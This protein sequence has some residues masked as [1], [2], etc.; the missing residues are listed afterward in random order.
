MLARTGQDDA[1][2]VDDRGDPGAGEALLAHQALQRGRVDAHH[3]EVAQAAADP[4]RHLDREI[5]VAADLGRVQVGHQDPVLAVAPHEFRQ[6]GDAPQRQLGAE[7]TAGVEQLAAVGGEQDHGAG[8]GR[9]GAARVLVEFAQVAARQRG[10]RR[11]GAQH[12]GVGPDLVVH[13]QGEGAR[14]LAHAA[15]LGFLL[16][17]VDI[18][19]RQ[20][21]RREG[22]DQD[23]E[24][25]QQKAVADT[26]TNRRRREGWGMPSQRRIIRGTMFRRR[27]RAGGAVQLELLLV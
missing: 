23:G 13:Q 9:R 19:D 1:L 22:G 16:F 18:G 7:G 20:R 15:V 10:R 24:H 8:R 2:A 11:Q 25:E 12:A 14:G 4:D 5:V 6:V 27:S 17:V 26:H 3:Q 21:G